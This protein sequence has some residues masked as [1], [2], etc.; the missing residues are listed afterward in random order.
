LTTAIVGLIVVVV[1]MKTNL[2]ASTK[3]YVVEFGMA[4]GVAGLESGAEVRVAGL[5]VGRVNGIEEHFDEGRIDVS[6]EMDASIP[7]YKNAE[8][9]RSQPLLGNYSW[10][11]FTNLGDASAGVLAEDA[12]LQA[13]VSGGLLATIVGPKNAGR[14]DKMFEDLSQFTGALQSFATEQYPKKVVPILDDIAL[15]AS[16]ARRDYATWRSDISRTLASAA[17]AAAKFDTTMDDAKVLA[18][19]AR[20]VMSHVR[21]K[22]IEQIDRILADAEV[23]AASL[24]NA[25]QTLDVEIGVRLP[26]LRAMLMDL[27]TA[28]AQIKL[29]TMEVRRSPWKLLHEPSSGEVGRENL[30]E[31]ARAF[32]LA[33]NDLR[34]AA[35]T[36]DAAT[37]TAPERF[38]N[39]ERF[40]KAVQDEVTSSMTRFQV[41]QQRL[42]DVLLDGKG[43]PPGSEQTARPFA[44]PPPAPSKPAPD[45]GA[46]PSPSSP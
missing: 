6:I 44:P 38:E 42:F 8:V 17:S 36:L 24:A 23:G 26:D 2:F 9:L 43:P 5:K 46:S 45:S 21:E 20:A 35:E 7:V 13:R 14:A 30:Y 39:D 31:A 22:N 34:V 3:S 10:L 29:A 28:A 41:A 40:R 12:R 15:L 18:A 19:D 33:S 16:D 27:R 4:D 25:L 32:A 1:L 37:R 11:N